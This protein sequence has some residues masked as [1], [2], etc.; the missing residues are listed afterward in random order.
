MDIARAMSISLFWGKTE[1]LNVNSGVILRI[2]LGWIKVAAVIGVK[3]GAGLEAKN[4]TKTVYGENAKES[5][6]VLVLLAFFL[7]ELGIH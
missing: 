5:R 7:G 4:K 6:V 1:K 3:C 2:A